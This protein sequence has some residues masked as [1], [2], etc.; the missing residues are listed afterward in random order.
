[1]NMSDFCN[2]TRDPGSYRV[3]ISRDMAVSGFKD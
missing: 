1:M 3:S 2:V